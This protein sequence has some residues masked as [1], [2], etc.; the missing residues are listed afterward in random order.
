MQ[1]QWKIAFCE[2]VE[3]H[4]QNVTTTWFKSS[5]VSARQRP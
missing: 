3:A 5:N 2:G 4:N 1:L